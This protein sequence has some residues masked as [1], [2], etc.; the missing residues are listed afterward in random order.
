VGLGVRG[1]ASPQIV[2]YVDFGVGQGRSA[3]FSGINYPF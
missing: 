3:V 2:G 1:V